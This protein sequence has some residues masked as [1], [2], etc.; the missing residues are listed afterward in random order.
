MAKR[1]RA[2]APEPP[3]RVFAITFTQ[4]GRFAF[5]RHLGCVETNAAYMQHGS[6]LCSDRGIR[7]DIC[8]QV[9]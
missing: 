1:K 9:S 2:S 5:T 6:T 3:K 8:S 7:I 4:P